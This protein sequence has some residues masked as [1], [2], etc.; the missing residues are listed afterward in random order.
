MTLPPATSTSIRL[1]S[2]LASGL[3]RR[4]E[5]ATREAAKRFVV[6]AAC[7]PVARDPGV[8]PAEVPA[9]VVVR[10]GR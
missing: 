10:L 1:G 5:S 3:R 7:A 2:G 8:H 9:G 6:A 4:V